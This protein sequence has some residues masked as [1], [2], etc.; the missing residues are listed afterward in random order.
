M[1]LHAYPRPAD[2]TGIGIHWCAGVGAATPEMV[3]E[4]W[5]RELIELGV[6]WVKIADQ[7]NALQLSQT[8]LA[9]Q[10][11][12][13]VQIVRDAPGPG[14][15][16]ATELEAVEQL[17]QAGVRYFE[18]DSE[19]DRAAFWGRERLPADALAVTARTAAANMEA[20]LERGGL[21]AIPALTPEGDWPLAEEIARVGGDAL[22]DQPIWLAI[23]NYSCNRPRTIPTT[24]PTGRVRRLRVNSTSRWRQR[25]G[26]AGPWLRSTTCAASWR[27][28]RISRPRP[29]TPPVLTGGRS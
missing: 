20:V 14:P 9:G 19:P 24:Q 25:R 27:T 5:L 2:D 3:E 13:I 4:F 22:F 7:R 6:K 21:P 15:L 11:M 26:R 23:H 12:P 16:S 8:L 1:N 17:V 29:M 10:I 18:F 28:E